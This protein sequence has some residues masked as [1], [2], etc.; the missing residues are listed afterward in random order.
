MN[1]DKTLVTPSCSLKA[2][3]MLSAILA[4]TALFVLGIANAIG[5]YFNQWD[6][7]FGLAGC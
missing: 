4:G 2:P 1:T 3:G 6:A 5:I 7:T